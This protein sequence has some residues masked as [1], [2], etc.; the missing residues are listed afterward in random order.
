MSAGSDI[1]SKESL[2]NTTKL[3]Q[4]SNKN[5][6]PRDSRSESLYESDFSSKAAKSGSKS[7]R[8]EEL[9]DSMVDLYH[10]RGLENRRQPGRGY[11]FSFRLN[12]I[13][14][15]SRCFLTRRTSFF[16][17]PDYSVR[18]KNIFVFFFFIL[19]TYFTTTK[20]QC[21]FKR[22]SIVRS[23][24]RESAI[25]REREKEISCRLYRQGDGLY[26]TVACV[27]TR[28]LS[29]DNAH[30]A[31]FDGQLEAGY[32][33]PHWVGEPAPGCN[34]PYPPS[35][36][37]EPSCLKAK[38]AS[39]IARRIA[40]HGKL[41]GQKFG[42][43]SFWRRGIFILFSFYLRVCVCEIC[44]NFLNVVSARFRR[45]SFSLWQ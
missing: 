43:R 5:L 11:P 10:S 32:A 14:L 22:F 28:G 41:F 26:D 34:I 6:G 39:G 30:P 31:V 19:L 3:S 13:N 35:F 1:T 16:F 44:I 7:E 21:S 4:S 45:V 27:G 20:F 2:I 40:R 15:A 37:G 42:I 25:S 23:W 24:L 12:F 18:G 9:A 38:P 17:S 29:R 36:R 33:L 8:D